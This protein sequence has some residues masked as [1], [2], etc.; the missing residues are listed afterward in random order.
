MGRLSGGAGVAL[1]GP[2]VAVLV[3]GLL[4]SG[5]GG[6][7]I[8]STNR[9]TPTAYVTA[10]CEAVG[11]FERDVAARSGSLTSTSSLTPAAGRSE[12][13]SYLGALSRD[14]R[15]AVA[16]LGAAGVPAVSGGNG[17]AATILSTFRRLELT[18]GRSEKLAAALPTT[19]QAAFRSAA[20]T[21]ATAV[22][23]S[24]GR[25]GVGLS[26][27]GNRVLDAAAAKVPACHA[28]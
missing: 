1:R 5:C 26:T 21:L 8:P 19:S 2:L 12:L 3:L 18:L 27:K 28:L 9:V 17:F 24:L 7:R 14:S 11:P 22:R 4:L 13:V 23:D 10:L 6:A 15:Q 20:V 16:R 25:L